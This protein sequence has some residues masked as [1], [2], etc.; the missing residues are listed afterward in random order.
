MEEWKEIQG[1]EGIYQISSLG[2]IKS[3]SRVMLI[4]G[5]Y[6][7]VT[8]EIILN[9]S[10]DKE[11]YIV[12]SLYLNGAKKSKKVHQ[13]VAIAFLNH[14]PN[15]HSLVVN[16]KDFNRTNNNKYN[17]EI[18]TTRVNS[19][20]K[21]LKSSSKY[22]GVNWHKRDEKWTACIRINGRLKHLGYFLNEYDAHL[23]Y[24]LALSK[25]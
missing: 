23:A 15:G 25:I 2:R 3:L 16:H 7:F 14:V 4:R 5:K 12:V 10:K 8:K 1:Y 11:G 24:E 20:K 9:Q 17:L 18:V 13:L 22:T 19:N 21:H 6:P